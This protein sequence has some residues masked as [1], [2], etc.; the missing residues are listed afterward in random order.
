VAQ[1]RE[2]TSLFLQRGKLRTILS[3]FDDAEN[4]KILAMT[5]QSS[6]ST[7]KY[8][9]HLVGSLKVRVTKGPVSFI[10]NQTL[11]KDNC[12][13]LVNNFDIYA[14][15]A[16]LLTGEHLLDKEK[17]YVTSIDLLDKY[18]NDTVRFRVLAKQ[19]RELTERYQQIIKDS[20]KHFSTSLEFDNKLRKQIQNRDGTKATQRVRKVLGMEKLTSIQL[21]SLIP[22]VYAC[23]DKRIVL[24]S[25]ESYMKMKE[26]SDRYEEK[27]EYLHDISRS[28]R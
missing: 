12:T 28:H 5:I 15:K 22:N 7:K 10:P 1:A 16:Y 17:V 8:V 13:D 9:Q 27:P 6:P 14:E 24:V 2:M 11:E 21:E 3:Q 19:E 26:L 20:R 18:K 25:P 4:V 23:V